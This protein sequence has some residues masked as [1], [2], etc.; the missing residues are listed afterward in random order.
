MLG[1]EMPHWSDDTPVRG[2][3]LRGLLST[4]SGS[5][6]VVGPHH[7]DLV[8]AIPARQVTVLVRGVPD[9]TRY[10][11]L[12]GVQ[13][14]CGSLEK[15]AA[16]PAYDT[17]IA[18][19]GLDRTGS[20]EDSAA[21]SWADGLD[22]LL[23][24]LRP[25]GLLLL[26]HGNPLG[27]HRLYAGA[28]TPGDADWAVA[29]DPGRPA[30][31]ETLSAHLHRAGLSVTG[32][33]AA[34]PAPRTPTTLVSRAALADPGRHGHLTSVLR[35]AG[36]PGGP[37]L[38]DP[39]PLAATLLDA[40]LAAALAPSWLVVAARPGHPP[41]SLPE[42]LRT[43]GLTGFAET[44]GRTGSAE[45]TGRPGLAA[46]VSGPPVPRGR[47]LHDA[48][49]AASRAG[50]RPEMRALLTA[51]QSG[52]TAGVPADAIIVGED[53]RLHPLAPPSD[54]PAVLHRLAAALRDE[55]QADEDAA[56]LAT[57]AGI[58]IPLSS[59]ST[60]ETLREVS[61]AHDRLA[62][63]VSDLQS[64]LRWY[65]SRIAA[66][67]SELARADRIIGVLKTTVP[68]K[69]AKAVLTGARTVIRRLRR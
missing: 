16:V 48:L 39:R 4:A 34:Y 41:L 13:V 55:G 29:D 54:P 24:V 28:T 10:A 32:E 30:R 56:W 27:L 12:P 63:Q 36:I 67:R 1:G 7:P 8:A 60:P 26:G 59:T 51:W 49:L 64:Q 20:T 11:T 45:T 21:L 14:C 37:L 69:A 65:E 47:C 42:V 68:G 61:A 18:L 44:T 40:G 57:M 50:D 62:L 58:E 23:S 35:R 9:A 19:D 15:L 5:T 31:L 66:L 53:G 17:V 6:L 46:T 22:R 38:A 52:D 2:E 33:Y 3:V 43:D 25:G